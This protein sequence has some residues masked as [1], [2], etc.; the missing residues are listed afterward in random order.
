MDC[1]VV[2]RPPPRASIHPFRRFGGDIRSI[3]Y[4]TMDKRVDNPVVRSLRFNFDEALVE[5]S[6]QM[7]L[8][9]MFGK[10]Q[11][12]A[13]DLGGRVEHFDFIAPPFLLQKPE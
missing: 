9:C 7:G 6:Q 4:S 5:H 12:G 10:N 13:F 3:R 2:T 8:M 1:D 11:L